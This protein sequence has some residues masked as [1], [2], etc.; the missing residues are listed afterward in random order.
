MADQ[1][2]IV[3]GFYSRVLFVLQFPKDRRRNYHFLKK[4][5]QHGL[6]AAQN[7]VVQWRSVGYNDAHERARIFANVALSASRSAAV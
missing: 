6:R 5:G 4:A 3:K 1:C 7:Q 2:E